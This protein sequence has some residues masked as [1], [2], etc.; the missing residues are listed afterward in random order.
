MLPL[1]TLYQFFTTFTCRDLQSSVDGRIL[2]VRVLT[3]LHFFNEAVVTLQRLLYGE[4]LPHMVDSNFRQVEGKVPTHKFDSTQP[5][6]EPNNLK[7]LESLVDKRVSPNLGA[8]YGPHLTC[9]LSL[10]QA[11]L[12]ITLADC[13]PCLPTFLAPK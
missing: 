7:V 3:D 11:H 2:K 12:L 10:A 8:L 1:F 5:L 6:L 13:I 9:H 4:R